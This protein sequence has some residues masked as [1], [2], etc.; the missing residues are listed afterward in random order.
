MNPDPRLLL[1]QQN[2][3]LREYTFGT[4]D[5]RVSIPVFHNAKDA[6][7]YGAP[8][9][10]L[11]FVLVSKLEELEQRCADLELLTI[12]GPG[13]IPVG[14]VNFEAC[15]DAGQR[16]FDRSQRADAEAITRPVDP[17]ELDD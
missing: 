14:P 11:V 2:V 1:A 13:W 6:A 9:D 7:T 16:L 17:A 4:G 3:P 5:G 15:K 10:L 8:I 12:A